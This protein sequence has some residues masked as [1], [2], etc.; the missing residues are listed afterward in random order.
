MEDAIEKALYILNLMYKIEY[1]SSDL[2]HMD[3][4]SDFFILKLEK[5]K[6]LKNELN[7]YK[8]N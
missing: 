3:I 2:V 5:L 1:I 4:D 6:S 8:K 7:G